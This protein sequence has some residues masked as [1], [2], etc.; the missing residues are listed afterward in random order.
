MYNLG[1]A[2][3]LFSDTLSNSDLNPNYR[4]LFSQYKIDIAYLREKTIS[5]IL[6]GL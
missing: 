4:I 5:V 6:P 2:L 1:G 3:Q